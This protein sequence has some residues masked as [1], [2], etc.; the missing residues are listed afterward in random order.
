MSA[1]LTVEWWKVRRASVVLVT[2]LLLVLAVPLLGLAMLLVAEGGGVGAVAAKADL[3]LT[4]D[5]WVGYLGLVGQVAAAAMFVGAGVVVAWVFGREHAE[6]TFAALYAAAVPRRAVAAAKLVV[7]A[8]WAVVVALAVTGVALVAGVLADVGA[9]PWGVIAPGL[10]RL[11]VVAASTTLLAVPVGWVA[12]AGRGYL[13]AIG[14]VV[15]VLAVAQ[16]VVLLGAGSWFPFAIPGLLAVSGAEGVP[17]PGAL[18]I[19]LAVLSVVGG[20]AATVWWWH[21]AEVA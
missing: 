10:G 2:T 9:E 3:L 15:V 8:G 6:G 14:A 20:G 16:V 19:A 7:V 5:G 17:S 12:S 18:G 4:G 11:L 21:R 13:P 1:A